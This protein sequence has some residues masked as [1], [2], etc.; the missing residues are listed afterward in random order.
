[1]RFESKKKLILFLGNLE[2]LDILE[3]LLKLFK[4]IVQKKTKKKYKKHSLRNSI[5]QQQRN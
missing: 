3:L 1:L 2:K 4:L 5:K